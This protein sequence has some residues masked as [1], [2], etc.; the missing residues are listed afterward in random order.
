MLCTVLQGYTPA[1]GNLSGGISRIFVGDPKDFD[2]THNGTDEDYTAI[3][4]APTSTGTLFPVDIVEDESEFKET[5]TLGSTSIKFENTLTAQ[6][7]HLSQAGN[8]FLLALMSASLCCGLLVVI[9]TNNGEI[10]V[11]G[12][13]LVNSASIPRFKVKLTAAEA[14]TGKLFEDFNGANITLQGN[15]SRGARTFSGGIAAIEAML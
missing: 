4:L 15:Y 10:F 3:A 6:I 5:T 12:E 11:M 1:C 8:E 9:E 13:S 2:F 14:T 7:R